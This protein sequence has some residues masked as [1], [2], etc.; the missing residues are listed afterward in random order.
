MRWLFV[1]SGALVCLNCKRLGGFLLI[2]AQTFIILTKDGQ[3]CRQTE[4]TPLE[5]N[6]F[7]NQVLQH[8]VIIGATLIYMLDNG[9]PVKVT[10]TNK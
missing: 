6:L 4:H 9:N 2:L 8:V 3:Y 1:V 5:R 10:A 7:I